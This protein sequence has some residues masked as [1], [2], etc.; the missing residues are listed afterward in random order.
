MVHRDH[1]INK[2]RGLKYTFKGRQKR[3]EL[4]RKNN[5]THYISVPL[6]DLLE[7]EYVRSTLH[8][9]GLQESEI[10]SFLASAKN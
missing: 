3:T 2:V 7:D 10:K 6:K 4:Y 9:A 8:Q 5:G 1:F